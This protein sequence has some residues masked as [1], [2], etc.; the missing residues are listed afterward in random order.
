MFEENRMHELWDC[1]VELLLKV[2]AKI[3]EEPR[4]F[5]MSAWFERYVCWPVPNCG[6]TACIGGWA[7][8]ISKQKTPEE[9]EGGWISPA[10]TL[11]LTGEQASRLFHLQNWPAEFRYEMYHAN[12]FH[13][14]SADELHKVLAKRAEIAARRIDHFI[15]TKGAE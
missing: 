6:T 10:N 13:V 1:N 12:P 4:Q 9:C 5:D 15:A 7:E 2:R 11:K 8:A 3:I 14:F